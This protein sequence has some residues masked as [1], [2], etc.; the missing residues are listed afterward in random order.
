MQN[1]EKLSRRIWLSPDTPEALAYLETRLDLV[2]ERGRVQVWRSC[3][4]YAAVDLQGS[5]DCTLYYATPELA[6][7]ALLR[8]LRAAGQ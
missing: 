7:R 6:E 8:L 3:H 5:E 1:P 4:G 2:G